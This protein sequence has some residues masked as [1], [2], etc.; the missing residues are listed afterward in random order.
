ML[1][2]NIFPEEV[3]R[4]T[5]LLSNREAIPPTLPDVTGTMRGLEIGRRIIASEAL[6]DDVVNL[7]IFQVQWL[8]AYPTDTAASFPEQDQEC[9]QQAHRCS[10]ARASRATC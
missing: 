10:S 8:R 2:R 6:C 4:D 7:T 1:G 5:H 9:S 3:M